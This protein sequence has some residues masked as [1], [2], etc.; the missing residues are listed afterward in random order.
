MIFGPHKDRAYGRRDSGASTDE[1]ESNRDFKS[2]CRSTDD[3]VR[4][5]VNNPRLLTYGLGGESSRSQR[6]AC[7]KEQNEGTESASS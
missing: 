1:K 7:P 3:T 5:Y 4:P 2:V 6:K